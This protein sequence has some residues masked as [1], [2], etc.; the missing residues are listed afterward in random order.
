MSKIKLF[1][2]W[3]LLGGTAYAGTCEDHRN[4][5]AANFVRDGWKLIS[6]TQDTDYLSITFRRS[7]GSDN[8]IATFFYTANKMLMMEALYKEMDDLK[9]ECLMDG[10]PAKMFFLNRQRRFKV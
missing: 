6:I 2:L 1:I 9:D 4:Y 3:V 10:K 8:Q 7:V 5:V